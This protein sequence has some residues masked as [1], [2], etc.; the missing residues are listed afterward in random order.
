MTAAFKTTKDYS[1]ATAI[2]SYTPIK[3]LNITLGQDKTF[4]GDGYR[5]ICCQIILLI[6]RF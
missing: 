3:Q 2:L 6:I 1:Y 4:I 5:S